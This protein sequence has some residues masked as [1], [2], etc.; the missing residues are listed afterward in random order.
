MKCLKLENVFV[1]FLNS[2]K[3]QSKKAENFNSSESKA[4]ALFGTITP[5]HYRFQS[6]KVENLKVECLKVKSV[7]FKS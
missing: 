1:K 7:N 5:S 2:S 4:F 3:S 6:V